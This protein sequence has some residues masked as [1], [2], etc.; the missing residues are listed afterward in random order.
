MCLDGKPLEILQ[1]QDEPDFLGEIREVI[2][3]KDQVHKFMFTDIRK[4]YGIFGTRWTIGLSAHLASDD[5]S[6]V[7]RHNK[8]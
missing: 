5:R 8:P 3:M 2:V 1:P 7:C 6:A 4:D